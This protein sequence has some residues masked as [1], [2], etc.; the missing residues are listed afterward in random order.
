MVVPEFRITV[1]HLTLL[2]LMP[3]SLAPDQI[4]EPSPEELKQA[5]AF[6]KLARLLSVRAMN[7]ENRKFIEDT[8]RDLRELLS[9]ADAAAEI[10]RKVSDL[11]FGPLGSRA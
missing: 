8:E 9:K 4:K 10:G 7:S 1:P 2:G 5:I 3:L 6:N 11:A